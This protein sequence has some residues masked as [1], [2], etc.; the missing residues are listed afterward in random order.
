MIRI[1]DKGILFG[2]G[3]VLLFQR[4][5]FVIPVVVL[6]TALI[7]SSF[8]LYLTDA[9]ILGILW[10]GYLVLCVIRPEFSYFLPL[11]LY[12][13]MWYSFYWGLAGVLFY[14][15]AREIYTGWM[16]MLWLLTAFLAVYMAY[17]SEKNDRLDADII[18]LR[19]TD[20]ELKLVMEQRNRELLEK[21]E[22]EIYLAT[23][24]ERN[25]IAREIHDNVGHMLSRS[26]LQVGALATICKE[27]TIRQ[28]L[29]GINDTL[30]QAM[31]SIRESVHDLHDD[32]ID[33]RQA[34]YEAV[35]DTP[36]F[37]SLQTKEERLHYLEEAAAK[38]AGAPDIE[39]A[40]TNGYVNLGGEKM[41]RQTAKR[42]YYTKDQREKTWPDVAGNVLDKSVESQRIV[43][44]LERIGYTKNE[45]RGLL[46]G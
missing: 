7:F 9:K 13:S 20:T 33:L 45:I 40:A 19:D 1:L 34:A 26:I 30:N 44:T 12:D 24:R 39:T 4:Q 21:Q 29:A 11:L 43:E 37:Q 35:K 36:E 3:A 17:K 5:E 23:L 16:S 31:N 25:R 8:S 32:A 38:Q 27:E 22:N 2:L 10:M 41:A 46:G 6:L 18:H 42:W 28:Q 15:P 14:Y